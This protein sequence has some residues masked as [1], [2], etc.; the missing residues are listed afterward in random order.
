MHFGHC[1]RL[2]F[3]DVDRVARKIVAQEEVVA[4][5]HE[6]GLLPRWLA[7]RGVKTVIVGGVGTRAQ[8][9]FAEN[10][11]EV[12]VGAPADPPD[13]LVAGYLAGTLETGANV[14]ER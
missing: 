6:P 11:I 13:K 1:E 4:P 2:A 12:V 8:G 3:M 5:K 9:L 14:C 10:G 7:E